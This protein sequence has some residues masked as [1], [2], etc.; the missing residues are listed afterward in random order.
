MTRIGTVANAIGLQERDG[1]RGVLMAMVD[2]RPRHAY[3]GNALELE[4]DDVGD[5]LYVAAGLFRD[6]SL[7]GN[8]GRS[9]ENLTRVLWLA[10]DADLLDFLGYPPDTDDESKAARKA[11]LD[12]LGRMPQDEL[13][14]L[15][16]GLRADLED[17]FRALGLPM[18]RL[19]YTGYGLCAYI[20]LAEDDQTR[21]LD[22]KAAHK[23]LVGRINQ[24]A[25]GEH[26]VDPKVNDG[27]TRVTR[28]PE[29]TNH[30]GAIAR[31]VQS[32]I[33]YTGETAP[34]GAN[35]EVPRAV[36]K[37]IPTSGPGLSQPDA[38]S[39][40]DAIRPSWTLGQKHAMGLAVAGMLAKGGVPEDQALAIIDTL[41][42]DDTKPY[43]RRAA[44]AS[45]YR[46]ARQGAPIAG[47]TQLTSLMP[48]AAVAFV[49]GV[50]GRY[51]QAA[52]TA[53]GPVSVGMFEVVGATAAKKSETKPDDA[54][55]FAPTP[56][57]DAAFRGWLGKYVELVSPTTAAPDSYH[58][59][60]GMA[61]IGSCIGRRVAFYHTS[62]RLFA[63]FYVLLIG[64]SGRA[65][66]D[67]AIK[68]AL[69]LPQLPSPPGGPLIAFNVAFRVQ[70][71]IASSQGLIGELKE[72]SNLLAYISE[73]AELMENAMRESTRTI[74]TTLIQAF[75]SP[76]VLQNTTKNNP[77]EARNPFLSILSGIQPEVMAELIAGRH[78]FSGF[79]NRWLL[80]VGEGKGAWAS[81]PNLDETAGWFLMRE[82]LDA[83]NG[84][85]EGT[86]LAFDA[87]AIDI[88]EQWFARTYGLATAN[89]SPQEDAMGIRLQTLV[90][91]AAIVY[92]VLD[93]SRA[94]QASH[95]ESAIALVD[96]SW[97]H[98]KK[99][100]PT[101]GEFPEA[102]LQ[103]LI[104]ET[105]ARR[106]PMPKRKV[107]QA[108]GHRMGPGVFARVVKAML[109]NGE[110]TVTPDN[111]IA[112][113]PEAA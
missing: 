99:L 97:G 44:V 53:S 52:S 12:E 96:W 26:L 90:K 6:G 68:R 80:V 83:I 20:Y 8:T 30:K 93:R 40:I 91:K 72:S 37:M 98:T 61:M 21:V 70:R 63:N 1:E 78:Q 64:P 94:I 23:L 95:L 18:H 11:M 77:L 104:L 89:A 31:L 79:L 106:G 92:A 36:G 43:D 113:A 71:S 28:L 56:L 39:I 27:G 47:Y 110:L 3:L 34:L 32:L 73:F 2:G 111:T 45:T 4:I 42:V 22:A 109:E 5:A 67:T 25:G 108:I 59:A 13:N 7:Q 103:R 17:A 66:K 10:F 57:P 16:D 76:P 86:T 15:I 58:L 75:D 14:T 112:I 105:L 87:G 84:Y 107:Q 19:D 74:T 48:A 60:C 69:A 38:Q 41:S 88:W 49:D 46:R 50:L 85:S 35:P 55:A 9:T 65:Y 81:P 29:S 62:E 51:R 102:R 101:W 100:L 82:A 24:H 33:P 54:P